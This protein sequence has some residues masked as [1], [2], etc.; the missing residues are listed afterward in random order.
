MYCD[1][2]PGSQIGQQLLLQLLLMRSNRVPCC[3]FVSAEI[4]DN[5]RK[6]GHE[7]VASRRKTKPCFEIAA[8]VEVVAERA[9]SLLDGPR[10]VENRYMGT[11]N[12]N[13]ESVSRPLKT[14]RC[15]TDFIP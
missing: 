11:V 4:R 12:L 5:G 15:I 14:Y 13:V 7:F 1:I 6:C 9:K 3:D 8:G 10:G 2:R